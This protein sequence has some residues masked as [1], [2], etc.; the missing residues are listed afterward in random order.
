MRVFLTG[1]SG[2]L[3]LRLTRALVARGDEVVG[4]ARS[5]AAAAAIRAAGGRAHPGRLDDAP[6]L[7]EGLRGA[8][9]VYHLAGAIRGPGAETADQVNHVGT[10]QLINAVR[11]SG[12]ATAGLVFTSSAAVYGDRSGLWV[13][14]DMP[15]LPHTAYGR[16]KVAAEAA[17]LEAHRDHGLRVRIVRLA[18]VYGA[19]FPFVQADRIRAGRAWLPGE[20]RNFVPTLHEDDAVAGLLRVG[21]AGPDGAVFNLADTSPV[22]L[23]DFYT[24][25]FAVVGGRPLRFWSTW[26]PSYVQFWA[27]RNNERIQAGLGAS[28]RFTPDSLRLFTASSR[29]KVDKLRKGLDFQWRFPD[30]LLGVRAALETAVAGP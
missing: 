18:A 15:P 26:I 8:E 22:P 1:A 14:E 12:A 16:S 10:R 11:A 4:L 25:V 30:P 29:L 2:R 13:E 23:R 3:G 20:G 5:E 9:R 28:P 24:A 21:E 7:R 27:A 6:A 19:G 17:L